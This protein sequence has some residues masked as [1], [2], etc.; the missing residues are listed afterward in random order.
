MGS[1]PKQPRWAVTK[2]MTVAGSGRAPA[3]SR[4]EQHPQLEKT[5]EQVGCAR[6]GPGHWE[7]RPPRRDRLAGQLPR[8]IRYEGTDKHGVDVWRVSA[9]LGRDQQRKRIE[10][11]VWAFGNRIPAQILPGEIADWYDDLT[12][13]GYTTQTTAQD[14]WSSSADARAAAQRL[15]QSLSEAAAPPPSP[16]PPPAVPA[17]SCAGG[18]GSGELAWSSSSTRR[19]RGAPLALSTRSCAARSG[20]ACSAAGSRWVRTR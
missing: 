7:L 6:P 8:G 20:S 13:H 5:C 11:R 19:P 2:L 9:Y 4:L 12:E 16:V 14:P 1:T 17:A 10:L 18:R 15:T 3:R